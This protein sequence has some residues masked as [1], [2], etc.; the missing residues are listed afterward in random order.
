MLRVV[1]CCLL[2]A[3]GQ[4][5]AVSP[6]IGFGVNKPPYVF[7]STRSGLEVEIVLAAF[8]AVGIEARPL[9]VPQNRLHVQLGAGQID[10]IATTSEQSGVNA[11]YSDVYLI[12]HNYAVS[13]AGNK[14]VI[15]RVEDLGRYS[16][17]AFQRAASILGPRFRD[18][19]AK[20]PSYTEQAQQR[21]RNL[22]LY[23]GR[24]DV[25]VGDKRIFNYFKHDVASQVDTAQPVVFHN[26]FPPTGYK[27]GFKTKALRDAFN[28][29]LAQIREDGT[30]AMIEK[31]YDDY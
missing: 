18:A 31:R 28:Q 15:N 17:T 3:W 25:V 5:W 9:F 20:C 27:V 19:I 2:A 11:F 6:W 8:K 23:L 29:G 4:A 21:T 26:I 24:V 7:E 30:Y 22:L 12:Y 10:A 1:L 14:L 13:L 16:V